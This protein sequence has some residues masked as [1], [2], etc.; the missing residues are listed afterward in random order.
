MKEVRQEVRFTADLAVLGVNFP[1]VRLPLE[2]T[3]HHTPL[4]VG[5]PAHN[6][7][8]LAVRF[9]LVVCCETSL[10]V[11]P[12]ANLVVQPEACLAAQFEADLG[13]PHPTAVGVDQVHH[14]RGVHQ[15]VRCKMDQKV[16][17]EI[18]LVVLQEVDLPLQLEADLEV[19]LGVS[20][21][22][23]YGADLVVMVPEVGLVVGHQAKEVR[24]I[25]AQEVVLVVL[26]IA[27][28]GRVAMLAAVAVQWAHNGATGVGHQ[29]LVMN[30]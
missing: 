13:A 2:P 4:I 14:C 8:S 7:V 29:W 17:F 16:W 1:G 3:V 9:S 25:V 23:Q 18:T 6:E 19:Q 22:V 20:L 15:R 12:E 21:E 28:R 27:G 5:L 26:H 10:L 24:C 11:Q 30:L